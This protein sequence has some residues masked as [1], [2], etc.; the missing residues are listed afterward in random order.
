MEEFTEEF[1]AL[2]ARRKAAREKLK[3]VTDP[4]EIK[5]LETVSQSS[6]QPLSLVKTKPFSSDSIWARAKPE[7]TPPAHGS[8]PS[9]FC[10]A[11]RS[12]RVVGQRPLQR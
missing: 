11:P 2:E 7:A 9:S 1:A 8:G 6:L 10:R 4:A 5:R 3:T 12:E